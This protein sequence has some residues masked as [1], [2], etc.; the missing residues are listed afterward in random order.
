MPASCTN[1]ENDSQ[2][3]PD[4]LVLID[5]AAEVDGYSSDITRTYPA[6]GSFTGPQRAI[7]EIVLSA[8]KKGVE[9]SFLEPTFGR[10]TMNAPG[11]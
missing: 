5:A 2:I 11:Y 8:Q 1:E 9:M 10:F 7:Y 3:G 4:D 6:S